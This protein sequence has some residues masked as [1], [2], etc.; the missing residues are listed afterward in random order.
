MLRDQGDIAQAVVSRRSVGQDVR[1]VAYLVTQSGA[2][3][4]PA[5][6]RDDLRQILP[7]Y[8]V[9]SAFV[10][11]PALPLTRNGKVDYRALPEPDWGQAAG[12]MSVAPRTPV[13]SR[14]ATMVAELLTLPGPVGVTDNFFALGGHSLTATKLMARI[15]AAYGVELPIRALFSDPTVAGLAATLAAAGGGADD[16]PGPARRPSRGAGGGDQART[17]VPGDRR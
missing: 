8:M 4:P 9:P 13:E 2:D 12:Q 17:L 6:L 16:S 14:L 1:L 3:T 11:L 15:K 5:G 7:D 10:V